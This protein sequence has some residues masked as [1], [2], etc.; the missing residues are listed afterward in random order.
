MR[1][2]RHKSVRS[3]GRKRWGKSGTRRGT[4]IE[5]EVK[6]V[7]EC[8]WMEVKEDGTLQRKYDSCHLRLSGR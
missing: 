1:K 4:Y 6:K 5:K 2:I 3:Q 8:G 7:R